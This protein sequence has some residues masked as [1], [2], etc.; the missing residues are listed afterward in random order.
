M[1]QA[2]HDRWG[3]MRSRWENLG[4]VD[5]FS[6]LVPEGCLTASEVEAAWKRGEPPSC[7]WAGF[8]LRVGHR[9]VAAVHLEKLA[10]FVL[11]LDGL[12]RP[13][14]TCA[15]ALARELGSSAIVYGPD[16]FSS[17]QLVFDVVAEC[18]SL[19]EVLAEAKRRCGESVGSVREMADEDAELHLD[20]RCYCVERI[21]QDDDAVLNVRVVGDAIDVLG[22]TISAI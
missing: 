13:L 2:S 17:F 19:T 5:E 10:G 14:Q 22:I 6:R 4:S 20:A 11:D 18:G 15:H 1:T 16:A 7:Q 12:R 9:A 21:E 3:V 8:T